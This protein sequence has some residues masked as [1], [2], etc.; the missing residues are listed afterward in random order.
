MKFAGVF[1]T[2]GM[3]TWVVDSRETTNEQAVAR[4]LELY[5]QRDGVRD[6]LV[7]RAGEARARLQEVF[8]TLITEAT[9][10]LRGQS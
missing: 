3:E 9:S 10:S 1:E 7:Q 5:R 2:V 6:S 8:R 4:V